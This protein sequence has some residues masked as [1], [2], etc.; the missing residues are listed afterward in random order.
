MDKSLATLLRKLTGILIWERQV[1]SVA[2]LPTEGRIG[3]QAVLAI[4]VTNQTEYRAFK[5]LHVM[6]KESNWLL[7]SP[8]FMALHPRAKKIIHS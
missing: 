8:L 3:K 2:H 1:P 7:E 6:L 4:L 5:Q